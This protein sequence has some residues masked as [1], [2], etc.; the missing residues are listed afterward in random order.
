MKFIFITSDKFPPFRVDL[1]ILFG[2]EMVQRGHTIHWLLQSEKACST[3][4]QTTWSDNRVWVCATDLGSSALNKIRKHVLDILNDFRMFRLVKK[5]RYDFIQ[6]KDKFISALLGIIVSRLYSYK[7]VY[8]LSYPF[9]EASIYKANT[10]TTRYPLYYKI[11]GYIFKHL[12]YRVIMPLA[13]KIFVQSNQMK[14]DVVA[15]GIPEQK[16]TSVPMGVSLN[17]IPY[18]PKATDFEKKKDE[19]IVLYLG[20]M[21]RIRRIDFL[22]RVFDY[23]LKH[24]L[25]A[26]LY[27]IGGSHDQADLAFLKKEVEKLG[28]EQSV[29][30]TDFVPMDKAWEYVEK[31]D[32][33][34]SPFYPTPI[35]NSTSPTKLAEYM[36]MGKPVVAN[37]HPEQRLVISESGGGIC[38]PYREK[39]FAEAIV[40]LLQNPDKAKTMGIKGR[41]Y[42]EENREY[43]KICDLVENQYYQL[44]S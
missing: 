2:K 7:F 22:I 15:M 38:V 5:N 24:E 25:K 17:M 10:G 3:S 4:F 18:N 16:L 43:S 37:D 44:I 32:V 11:R 21:I 33:C 1:K 19:K 13:D 8:W 14:K 39:E 26:K 12:L 20:T 9:P 29:V 34:V 41:A 36:A 42:I 35:L 30:F 40:C 6:V 27:M 31:A 23:V 28:M